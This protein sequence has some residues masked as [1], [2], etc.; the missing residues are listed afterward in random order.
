MAS[1]IVKYDACTINIYFY[2]PLICFFFS[3]KTY[4][5]FRSEQLSQMIQKNYN[6]LK[7]PSS[8]MTLPLPTPRKQIPVAMN[9]SSSLASSSLTS[10]TSS[11]SSLSSPSSPRS[12]HENRKLP[13]AMVRTVKTTHTGNALSSKKC[14]LLRI[15]KQNEKLKNGRGLTNGVNGFN[16][17]PNKIPVF[18]GS[19]YAKD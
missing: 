4:S 1:M 19:S 13:T 10:V 8:A 9:S 5:P 6:S 18:N 14:N 12:Q 16:G 11:L 17:S 15:D 2:K 3:S 7:S